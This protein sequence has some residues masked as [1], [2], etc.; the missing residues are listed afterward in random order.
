MEYTFKFTVQANSQEDANETIK[1]IDK[2]YKNVENQDLI[3]LANAVER[4]PSL[5]KKA[6]SF[7]K[8]KVF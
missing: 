1:A 4:N 3:K 5:V 6:L 2:I 7:L 8:F